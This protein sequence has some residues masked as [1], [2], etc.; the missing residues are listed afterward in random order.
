VARAGGRRRRVWVSREPTP[1][2]EQPSAARRHRSRGRGGA[3]RRPRAGGGEIERPPPPRRSAA[4]HRERG[5]TGLVVAL[6]KKTMVEMV[7][8]WIEKTAL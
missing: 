3:A 6:K 8:G 2:R 7:A 5:P 1:K 4:L